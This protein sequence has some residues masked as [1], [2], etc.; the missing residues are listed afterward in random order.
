MTAGAHV[1]LLVD[2]RAGRRIDLRAVDGRARGAADDV[3]TGHARRR[4]RSWRRGERQAHANRA[5]VLLVGRIDCNAIDAARAR[6]QVRRRVI[7]DRADITD[8]DRGRIGKLAARH[9][10]ARALGERVH[11]RRRAGDRRGG[12]AVDVV[13]H[14]THT[15]A[16][17]A[18][19]KGGR[20][21]Q[22]FDAL[23]VVRQYGDVVLRRDLRAGVDARLD[24]VVHQ[25]D[26]QRAGAANVATATDANRNRADVCGVAGRRRGAGGGHS[27]I[28]RLVDPT[29]DAAF[30]EGVDGRGNAVD[31]DA[32]ADTDVAGHRSGACERVDARGIVG[33]DNQGVRGVAGPAVADAGFH[34]AG[35]VVGGDRA[36]ERAVARAAGGDRE[37][38]DGGL[39][40]G[41]DRHR[42]GDRKLRFGEGGRGCAA[43]QIDADRAAHGCVLRAGNGAGQRVDIHLVECGHRQRLGRRAVGACQTMGLRTHR[44]V[45]DRVVVGSCHRDIGCGGA[46]HGHGFGRAFAAGID[47]DR[48]GGVEVDAIEQRGCGVANHH[49]IDGGADRGFLR[50]RDAAGEGADAAVVVGIDI[51]RAGGDDGGANLGFGGVAGLAPAER[52]TDCDFLA[53]RTRNGAREDVGIRLR[54]EL[55][56][57]VG[58]VDA[59]ALGVERAAARGGLDG[60]VDFVVGDRDARGRA[61]GHGHVAGQRLDLRGVL[62]QRFDAAR[63]DARIVDQHAIGIAD[64]VGRGRTQTGELA[65]GRAN[66]NGCGNDAGVVG[67]LEIDLFGARIERGVVDRH[68]VHVVHVAADERHTDIV[69]ADLHEA[70]DRNNRSARQSGLAL[71]GLQRGAGVVVLGPVGDA[72][73][74]QRVKRCNR[75]ARSCGNVDVAFAIDHGAAIDR[76]ARGVGDFVPDECAG[77]AVGIWT[78]AAHGCSRSDQCRIDRADRN[79]I[80]V[81]DTTAV[82]GRLGRA[83]DLG[84]GKCHADVGIAAGAE[85][86]VQA[87]AADAGARAVVG[88]D[89]DA[90]VGRRGRTLHRRAIQHGAR[91]VLRLR[92]RERAAE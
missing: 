1:D 11:L 6:R 39:R 49:R 9:Q 27:D 88:G 66:A 62:R 74:D 75:C 42:V 56:A 18:A 41:I 40:V 28:A 86:D 72:A 68:F 26:S 44:V 20:T 60:V 90:A 53:D 35:D 21:G 7:A 70:C 19:T 14:H 24:V 76:G 10:A 64:H 12:F 36:T 8:V 81:I 57:A 50:Y 32:C 83:A 91:V 23:L 61:L 84:V 33:G 77:D 71:V 5:D 52:P 17:R 2:G 79:C 67:R 89:I 37:R 31:R 16:R 47:L 59:F 85:I 48:T 80:N 78:A 15:N 65:L 55:D 30:D 38:V 46:G 73:G 54:R 29:V 58:A 3:D 69:L 34:L 4:E 82:H 45:D 22:H 13:D 63:S 87:A 92:N 51:E 43:N 25:V